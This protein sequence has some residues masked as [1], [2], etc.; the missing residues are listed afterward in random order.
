MCGEHCKNA[1][2]FH[3]DAGSSPHVRGTPIR[4]VTNFQCAG[5]I[6]ACAGNTPS[7]YPKYTGFG[8]HPRMCGEHYSSGVSA[9]S[10]A[11]SSPHVRGTRHE[12]GATSDSLGIIPACAGNTF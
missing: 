1:P 7:A 6:P 12:K 4:C 10:L 8:D 5:I 11:G 3:A 2:K 9:S